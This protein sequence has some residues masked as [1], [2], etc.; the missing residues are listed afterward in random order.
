MNR[1]ALSA[2]ALV[3]V[4]LLAAHAGAQTYLYNQA[5][6]GTGN[7]PS[8]MAAAD[9]NQDGR[10]DLVVTNQADNTVSVILSKPNGTFAVR[11]D[12]AVGAAPMAVVSADFNGDGIQDLAVANSKDNTVS[13]LLGAG[14]GK[15]GSQVTFPTGTTPV[16]VVAA[17]FNGDGKLDLAVLN[18][19]AGTISILP[20][21]GDG[22][23][24]NAS[25]VDSV[26]SPIAILVGDFNGDGSPDLV[27]VNASG[28]LS[29]LLNNGN[30]G[31]STGSSPT[32]AGSAGGMTEGD[33]NNDGKL[34]F[35]VAVPGN[36]L[37]AVYMGNGDG[38]F[39]VTEAAGG[40]LAAEDGQT[41]GVGPSFVTCG[42]FNGDGILDLAVSGEVYANGPAFTAIS[43]GNGDGTFQTPQV[44][45]FGGTMGPVVAADFNNDNYSDLAAINAMGNVVLVSLGGVLPTHADITLPSS[46]GFLGVA[47]ADF[48]GDGKIDAGFLQVSQTGTGVLTDTG[49][50]TVLPS[51]GDGTFQAPITTQLSQIGIGPMVAGD[52]NGDGKA[53]IAMADP[54]PPA[55]GA[56]TIVLGNG[57]GTFGSPIPSPV[58]LA[59]PNIQVMATGDFNGDGKTDIAVGTLSTDNTQSPIYVLLSNGDGT[60][61][62]NLVY[63]PPSF[64]SGISVADFN[65]DGK[66]DLAISIDVAREV[67][68][69]LG[70]GDGTFSGPITC[71]LSNVLSVG[72]VNAADF[73]GDG[74]VDLSVVTDQGF[75]FFAGNG[76]G[77]FKSG[78]TQSIPTASGLPVVGDF[79]GDGKADIAFSATGTEVFTSNGDGTLNDG[80]GYVPTWSYSRY[81]AG[82]F[83]SDGSLDLMQLSSNSPELVVPQTGTVWLSSPAVSLSTSGLNLTSQVGATSA[84]QAITLTNVGNGRLSIANISASSGFSE[85]NNCPST[86]N[87]GQGCTLNVVFTPTAGGAAVGSLT[88]TDN[89]Y[90]G[91]QVIT[92]IGS[93]GSSDFAVSALS[94]SATVTAGGSADYT[95]SILG[96]RG[97]SGTVQLSCSGAPT[98]ASCALSRSAASISGSTPDTVM[99][100]VTTTARTAAAL[101]KPVRRTR[102]TLAGFLIPGL[103]FLGST[104]LFARKRGWAGTIAIAFAMTA[105]LGG[106]IACS[107]AGSQMS[108]SQGG[109]G[110]GGS[111]TP[112]GT[113]AGTYTLTLT[114]SSGSLSHS[115]TVTLTVK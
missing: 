4:C 86:L 20:G 38:T 49:F 36:N 15:F 114:A 78:V 13:I 85:A 61:H 83:N 76:D 93:T 103:F 109:G 67:L 65:H 24:G 23:F 14:G 115:T 97:F 40:E 106:M 60:F 64:V 19:G 22:T 55:A 91:T 102:A 96:I 90:P 80:I 34:D 69:F 111:S 52:F 108:G 71:P 92:L 7:Q 87:V 17:D 53:D 28:D 2:L 70:N 100:T 104:L 37:I 95:L 84:A 27:A 105:M 72:G 77:T 44:A 112:S 42:D 43:L 110:S 47:S 89:A 59:S 21:N 101:S 73:N 3:S 54:A 30:G 33:F 82:D 5:G 35:A 10:L 32:S 9:F 99:L 51:N 1:A 29:V 16:G 57:D 113:P 50:M 41:V 8:G 45:H 58:N 79:N 6:L 66:A 31:F 11:T 74:N 56:L 75:V 98:Q 25:S 39:K 48:T 12:Y 18:T 62:A 81:L 63:A 88:L 26:A 68:V 107:G 94:S 46:E